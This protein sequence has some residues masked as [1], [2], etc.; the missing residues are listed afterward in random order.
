MNYF[1]SYIF[2]LVIRV[3]GLLPLRVLYFISDLIYYFIFHILKY[4]KK[5]VYENLKNSFPN[6]TDEEIKV[7]AK[8]FYRHLCDLFIETIYQ[9]AMD[10]NEI[11]RRVRFK[12]PE[13]IDDY[14][15]K[16]K[17][18]AA[19]MGHYNNWEWMCGFPLITPYKCIT[20]YRQLKDKVFDRHMFDMRS[21]FGAVLVPMKMS[22]RKIYEYNQAGQLT[23]T[24]FISDQAPPREKALFWIDFLNQDTPVYLG[25]QQIAKKLDMAVVFFKMKK[26][27]RGYYEFEFVPLFDNASE[28]NGNEITV[29]HVK[30]LEKLITDQPQYWLWSHRRWKVRREERIKQTAGLNDEKISI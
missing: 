9:P 17:H 30:E 3:I 15:R 28:T 27:R 22:I 29:A 7:V 13:I 5:V 21:R 11:R 19:V 26:I 24:A 12:N 8:K 23:I 25:P 2:Y 1:F 4:R 18:I 14:Y 6:K 10:E 16:G 20:I